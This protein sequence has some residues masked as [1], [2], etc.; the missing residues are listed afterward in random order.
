MVLTVDYCPL[1]REREVRAKLMEVGASPQGIELMVKKAIIYPL[2]ISGL[3]LPAANIVKQLALS[4]GAEAVLHRDVL[5]G[6]AEGKPLLLLAT[7]KQHK[8]I[9]QGLRRNQ[10]SLP[11]LAE[12]IEETLRVIKCDYWQIAYDGGR[13]EL[14]KRPLL[15]GILNITPDSFFDGGRYLNLHQ[16]V[17]HVHDLQASGADIIDIGG[18]SSRPGH[19]E[20][21]E[22]EE[23]DRVLPLI[24]TL[25]DITIPMSVDTDKPAVARDALKVGAKIINDIGGLQ[26]RQMLELA[27]ESKAPV[28]VMHQGADKN[29]LMGEI[30]RFFTG[31]LQRAEQYGIEEEK[32]IFDPGLGFGKDTDDNLE[33]VKNLK[34]LR[35]FGRPILLGFSNKRFIGDI[36]DKP[37]EDRLIGTVAVTTWAVAQR[38]EILRVHNVEAIGQAVR[39]TE[40]IMSGRA[41]LNG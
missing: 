36:L 21:S 9:C 22:R 25:A 23:S 27:A 16:A 20:V 6:G 1:R 10:F 28:I 40:A 35:V 38:V 18:A 41:G 5:I 4:K 14:G 37:V 17:D 7:E 31:V 11:E 15:M 24:E 33:I 29:D 13:L 8:E 26:N 32:L 2:E 30:E 39:M 3:S 12:K 19:E 34:H